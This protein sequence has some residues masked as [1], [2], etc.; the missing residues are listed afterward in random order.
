MVGSAATYPLHTLLFS[1]LIIIVVGDGFGDKAFPLERRKHNPDCFFYYPPAMVPLALVGFS[2]FLL[3]SSPPA[4]V[5]ITQYH[6][7]HLPSP[8]PLHLLIV[9]LRGRRCHCP[10]AHVSRL[11]RLPPPTLV[12][13]GGSRR[14]QSVSS[15]V[16]IVVVPPAIPL[17]LPQSSRGC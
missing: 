17:L 8:L 3:C 12:A 4:S 10:P 16:V 2:L 13:S 9:V 6:H 5:V 7:C 14:Q 1:L 11:C 15:I